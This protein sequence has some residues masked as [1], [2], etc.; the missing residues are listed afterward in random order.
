MR[1]VQREYKEHSY[2]EKFPIKI[3]N[4]F[5]RIVIGVL[6]CICGIGIFSSPVLANPMG[7]EVAAGAVTIT[8]P[9]ANH[10]QINQTSQ[11]AIINW[12]SFNIGQHQLTHFQQPAGG[13]ALNRINP[14]QGVSAI[15]GRLTATGKIIL[16]NP[17]GIFF[18][19]SAFVNVGSLIA[20][21][22]NITDAD[23][24]NGKYNF[25]QSSSYSGSVI[26][27][28]SILAARHGL[29]ALIGD[30]I[31]NNGLIQADLGNIILAT[32]NAA[33]ITFAANQ[34]IGFVVTV[35]SAHGGS[36][37]N[38]G[39]LRA[40]GG[41]IIVSANTASN[42]LD[43][44]INLNGI[45]Q[46]TSVR[47]HHGEIIL[48]ANGGS[49]VVNINGKL[50]VSGRTAKQHGGNITITGST[51]FIGSKAVIDAS[52]SAGG[53]TIL[54]GG[55][56]HG[57]GTLTNA[58]NL[59][60]EAGALIKADA[61]INGNGGTVVLWSDGTTDF[62]GN[63]S[64]IGGGSGGNGGFAEVSGHQL[65]NFNGTVNLSAAQ[66]VTG[67][68][69]LDPE[70]LT[71]QAAGPTTA[72][73]AGS[74]FT[75]NVDNS[76]LTVAD[77]QAALANANVLVQTGSGGLQA[78]DITVADNISW[79]NLNTLTLSAYRNININATITNSAGGHLNL[80]A[81]NTGTGIGTIIFSAVT[82]QI[83]FSGSGAVNFYYNPASFPT[84]TNYAGNVNVSGGTTFIAYM[85]V[86]NV[87]NLQNINN[88][89][90]GNYALGTNIDASATLGWNAGAGFV[91]IGTIAAS[92]TGQFDGQNHT[93]NG[94]SIA[95]PL[96]SDVGLFGYVNTSGM[97]QN[98]GLTNMTI[99]GLNDTGSLIGYDAAGG[100]VN[101]VY[102]TGS[103][104]SAAISS[105]IGGLIG[106]SNDVISNSYTTA[107]VLAGATSNYVGG[108]VGEETADIINSYHAS[109][110]VTAGAASDYVGGLVGYNEGSVSHAYNTGAVGIGA[111]GSAYVGGL[112]GYSSGNVYYSYSTGAVTTGAAVTNVGGLIGYSL[113][114]INNS[115]STGAIVTGATGTTNVGGLV[116]YAGNNVTNSIEHE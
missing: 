48:S 88:N 4:H 5:S 59:T 47:M 64:A 76:I 1:R 45:V 89:L 34:L 33:T 68:L 102:S 104:T 8:R 70:N 20:S 10:L 98:V 107:T 62:A 96:A 109:G 75:S 9:S 53:G 42:V 16:I 28:G 61:L 36:I 69:L 56:L 106:F 82:P 29:V 94:L 11:T 43:N 21:T 86:N 54:I 12:Q 83:N 79:S 46:A 44:V 39:T 63:I 38:T 25:A 32:G 81:D 55:D 30:N 15:Y 105:Y 84:P 31:Q 41:R 7:G 65:L 93:I 57:A 17:A 108:L 6:T 92:F 58:F 80:N 37:N 103:V 67:T 113:G 40:N 26:N 90:S 85:L 111:T 2:W 78:G 73:N 14:T 72:T 99:T 110:S 95:L 71:I 115:Y 60:V 13:V 50:N 35:K 52:G 101:N 49:G 91:P 51:I 87:T 74:V 24:L 100:A 112:I 114:T 116:G 18:G 19:P 97:I 22:A 77:L 27:Q 23:F 3:R 66:G